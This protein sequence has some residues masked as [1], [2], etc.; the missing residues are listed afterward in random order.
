M[1]T[2][3]LTKPTAPYCVQM[4]KDIKLVVSWTQYSALGEAKT[5]SKTL[6]QFRL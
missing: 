4:L 3:V 2:L 5:L 1:L 6:Y